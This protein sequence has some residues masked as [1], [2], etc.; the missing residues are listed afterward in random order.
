MKKFLKPTALVLSL[1]MIFA[2]GFVRLQPEPVLTQED[3]NTQ[4]ANELVEMIT[5][6][7]R[8]TEDEHAEAVLASGGSH[9]KYD[10]VIILPGI[11]HSKAYLADENGNPVYN[12]KGEKIEGQNLIIDTE[13]LIKTA[14]KKLALPLVGMLTTQHD[15]GFTKAAG[16]VAE[17]AFSV[18]KADNNGDTINN[19]QVV[20]YESMAKV[21]D[22]DYDWLNRMVPMKDMMEIIG[23]DH[24]YFF[25]F[26]LAGDPM[27]S[28]DELDEYIQ[29]VKKETGHKKV[30][31]LSVSLGGTLFTAYIEKY[32]QKNDVACAVNAVAVLNGTNIIDDFFYRRW[33]LSD[34]FI[35]NEYLPL[36]MAEGNDTS[37]LGYFLNL[38]I[39]II[40][41]D[42]LMD[43]L[44]AVYDELYDNVL[45]KIP[46]FWAM[47]SK[48]AYA[49]LAP[50][51]IGGEEYAVLKQ[52]TDAYQKARVNVEKNM[53]YMMKNG[54][55]IHNICGYNLFSGDVQYAMFK[56]A[57]SAQK[58]NSDSIIPIQSTALGCTA[59]LP[60][61]QL[62]GYSGKYLSPDKNIY[63]GTCALPDNT[64]F[65]K[66]MHHEDAGNNAATMNLIKEIFINKNF[67]NINY[68]PAKYPQFNYGTN[69]KS[70]RRW[71]L[72]D[73]KAVD[74][75]ALT[76]EQKAQLNAAIKEGDRVL[77]Q[78][79][80]NQDEVTAATQQVQEALVAVGA[81]EAAKEP[82]RFA[83]FFEAMFRFFSD[84]AYKT[85]GGRAYSDVP[86]DAV[87]G[88]FGIK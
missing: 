26:N 13:S 4:A 87:K 50:K 28:A 32:K 60:G 83:E 3:A 29:K 65:F 6:T 67:K 34:E 63:A 22:A 62:K 44:T 24:M 20:R 82:S 45:T 18:Q 51:L 54:T 71:D 9:C 43:T 72:P 76:N 53:K 23:E 81:K 17:E 39:R 70:L 35:Y 86:K 84:T 33:N 7:A 61:E 2:A 41:K 49:D 36:I 77:A 38:V 46:Q 27:D 56:I 80:G 69:N 78:T 15:T 58:V 40:P 68:N 88:L 48:E 25:T 74:Q 73:A 66:D 5:Q 79:I 8:E 47:I 1:V 12:S 55:R 31:L 19:I 52:R 42:V 14:V 16:E 21:S 37:T 10:P 85:V 64:W 59:A 30:N 11:N 57:A 75:S